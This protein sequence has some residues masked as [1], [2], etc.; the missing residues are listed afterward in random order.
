M[1][2]AGYKFFKTRLKDRTEKDFYD[3]VYDALTAYIPYITFDYHIISA[4]R[5]KE[6]IRYVYEDNPSFF[7]FSPYRITYRA[8]NPAAIN[9]NYLYDRK[10]S[11]EHEYQIKKIIMNFFDQYQ[12]LKLPKYNRIQIFHNLISSIC[13]YDPEVSSGGD[14][15][16]EDYNIIGVFKGKMA[17][18][19]GFSQVFKLLCDYGGISCLI[20]TGRCYGMTNGLHAW[21]MVEYDGDFYH[22]DA[23]WD[24]SKDKN[25]GLLGAYT[26]FM[27][28]D[29]WMKKSREL[30]I[31]DVFPKSCGLQYTFFGYNG[32][33][34]TNYHQLSDYIYQR[35]KEY[36]KEIIVYIE[37]HQLS[38]DILNTAYLNAINR[39][40]IK[41]KLIKEKVY[42]DID[43]KYGI[44]RIIIE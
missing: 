7:Y 13:T 9:F 12:V 15:V 6:I 4:K 32:Y 35:L 30:N 43:V 17:V 10:T 38:Y 29:D 44:A 22:I 39:L 37:D 20:A 41:D 26:Y 36:P 5:A 33:M 1:F 11:E 3:Q 42:Y 23:T 8:G 31:Y 27:V 34:I 24:L 28:D 40:D 21:N 2:K 18:C 25:K 19:Y 16:N 14:G